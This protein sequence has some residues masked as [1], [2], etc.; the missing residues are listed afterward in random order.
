MFIFAYAL[1]WA[2]VPM[3]VY[4]DAS[5]NKIGKIEGENSGSQLNKRAANWALL[6]LFSGGL[7]LILYLS[8]R[9][10]LIERAKVHPVV[11]GFGHRMIVGFILLWLPFSV[12]INVINDARLTKNQTHIE[13]R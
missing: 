8:N 11:L 2:T 4:L 6:I 13:G 10:K 3:L 1:F 7:L 9:K 5:G 12:L